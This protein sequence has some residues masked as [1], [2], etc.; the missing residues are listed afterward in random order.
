MLSIRS[1]TAADLPAALEAS[2]AILPDVESDIARDAAQLDRVL[3]L[4]VT[5][6]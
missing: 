4:R 5:A 2:R 1:M 6:S 3:R